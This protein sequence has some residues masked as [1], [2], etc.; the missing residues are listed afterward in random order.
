[1]LSA[2]FVALLAVTLKETTSDKRLISSASLEQRQ[3]AEAVAKKTNSQSTEK[4]EKCSYE[5]IY[6]TN[7]SYIIHPEFDLIRYI[8]PTLKL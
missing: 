1:M 3:S 5:F 7:D 8:K 6:Y 4:P 2:A